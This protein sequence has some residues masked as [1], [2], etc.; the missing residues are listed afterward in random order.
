MAT[1]APTEIVSTPD[2]LG[3]EPRIAG[4]RLG[5]YFLATLVEDAEMDP[6]DVADEYDL[7]VAAVYRALTYFHEHPDE[8]AALERERADRRAAAADSPNVATTPGELVAYAQHGDA[9]ATDDVDPDDT[10]S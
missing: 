10:D 5:V 1:Q 6:H 7:P 9:T 4:R 2:V 8:M 3:G